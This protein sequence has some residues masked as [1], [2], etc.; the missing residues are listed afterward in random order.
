MGRLEGKVSFVTGAASGIGFA[1]AKRFAEEGAVVVGLDINE[2]DAWSE[3]EKL[4]P[5]AAFHVVDVRDEAGLKA[6]AEATAQ[7]FGHIDVCVTSAGVASG[8]PVHLLPT[9]EWDR[10]QDINLKGT[11]LTAKAVLPAMIEQRSGSIITIASVE[12]LEG[13]EGGSTYNASKGGVVLL[14]KN[15]AMDYGRLEIRANCICPGFIE[16]PLFESMIGNEAMSEV[17]AL[18]K[19]QHKIRRFGKPE[20]IAAAALFFASDDSVFVSGQALSVD[21]GYTAGK[22][23]GITKMMGLE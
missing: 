4:A 17:R 22:S 21:G 8:G 12:G 23:F 19:E 18:I 6:A 13:N 5:G 20:E 14:T 3:V 11:F 9:E 7:A 16:T 15:L 2:G 10:V 1:C